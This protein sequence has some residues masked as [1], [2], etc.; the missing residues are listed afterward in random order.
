VSK[1]TDVTAS[2][3]GNYSIDKDINADV[4]VNEKGDVKATFAHS[5]LVDGLKTTVSG[6]P[7]N[8]A[9]TLKIANQ[10]LHSDM[11]VKADISGVLGTPKVDA[12]VLYNLGDMQVGVEAAVSEKGV[13]GYA[14]G[15]QTKIDDITAA[16]IVADKME[17]LKASGVMKLDSNTTAA[18]EAVY[19]LKSGDLKVSA[20]ATTK[21]DNGHTTRL[22]LSSAGN[23]QVVYA[24]E[25]AKGLQ[26]T[27]CAQVDQALKYKYGLQ[28]NYKM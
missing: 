16:L 2:A 1:G 3:T 5:G 13:S 17:T 19:K 4:T 6:E 26:G 15:L 7:A 10:L 27:A 28:F 24:G 18:V 20:G 23:A 11:G 25:V 9:R 21:L 12:S 22:V 8:L 14:L